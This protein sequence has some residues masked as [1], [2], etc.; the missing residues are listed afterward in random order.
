MATFIGNFVTSGVAGTK[1]L[2]QLKCNSSNGLFKKRRNLA[3][4]Y[5]GLRF[6]FE[7]WKCFCHMKGSL[8]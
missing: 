4:I 2:N 7:N 5:F 6:S 1:Y 8:Y 3:M